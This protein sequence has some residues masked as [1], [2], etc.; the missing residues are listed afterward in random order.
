MVKIIIDTDMGPDCDDA[1]A[2][3]L[4]HNLQ[5]RGECEILAITHCTSPIEGTNTISA[6]NSFYKQDHI[7]VGRCD[8]KS[9][10]DGEFQLRYTS[11]ISKM[12]LKKHKQP[13]YYDAVKLLRRVL[14]ENKDVV[15]I[16]I[17]TFNNI[18][19]LM[20]SQPD[21]IS[22]K[23]GVELVRDSVRLFSTMGADFRVGEPWAEF[24]VRMDIEASKYFAENCPVKIVYSPCLMG[25]EISTGK[26]LRN[27][28][29][30]N[31]VKIAYDIYTDGKEIRYSYDLLSVYY[32]VRG[33]D[34]LFKE[35]ENLKI[36]FDD[37]G[38]TLYEKGG[39][40]SY[41]ENMAPKYIIEE[42]LE[43]LLCE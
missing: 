17:G 5:R 8:K 25:E 41:L 2:L 24:N 7:P 18:S 40:D 21:E 22:D 6:I 20:K 14:S 33:C 4:A 42:K 23:T 19:A 43:E 15:F 29:D 39:K 3:A 9:F 38:Y 16:T 11:V 36:S 12:Y 1:G 13:Q 27:T 10:L 30:E 31:P 35:N 34:G 26:N 37:K 32:G 28:S